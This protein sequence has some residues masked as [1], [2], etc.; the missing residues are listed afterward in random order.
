MPS[1]KPFKCR[2]VNTGVEFSHYCAC[3]R[4]KVDYKVRYIIFEIYVANKKTFASFSDKMRLL[5]KSSNSYIVHPHSEFYHSV[6]ADY[7]TYPCVSSTWSSTSPLDESLRMVRDMGNMLRMNGKQNQK[8][9]YPD[10][11]Y[12]TTICGGLSHYRPYLYFPSVQ[13]IKSLITCW[14]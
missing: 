3:S 7:S 14:M 8:P 5:K 4:H 11:R 12:Q 6:M 2:H 1:L 9:H 13:I 10:R